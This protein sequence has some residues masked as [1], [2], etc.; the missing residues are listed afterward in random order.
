LG[1]SGKIMKISKDKLFNIKRELFVIAF[2]VL[3]TIV[4]TYPLVFNL[5]DTISYGIDSNLVVWIMSWDIHSF[6][7]NIGNIFNT[8][9]FFP[10]E[11]TLAYSEHF[12]GEALLAWPI[13]ALTGNIVFAYNV[14]LFSLFVFIGIFVH[15]IKS[16]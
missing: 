10:N 6:T 8:N 2:F 13:F 15:F 3:I 11:N 9:T 14:I 7:D 12:I 5:T 1:K 16:L 4:I